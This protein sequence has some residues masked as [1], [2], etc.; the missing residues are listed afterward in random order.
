MADQV[1]T[2]KQEKFCQEVAA[3]ASLTDAAI[4]AGYSIDTSGIIGW[5]NMQKLYIRKRINELQGEVAQDFSFLVWPAVQTLKTIMEAPGASESARVAAAEKILKLTGAMV[6][7]SE[8]KVTTELS[9]EAQ[10]LRDK[11]NSLKPNDGR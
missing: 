1:L 11:L 10:E 6:E 5:Q 8:S 3:G 7:R 9:P 2:E 4:R